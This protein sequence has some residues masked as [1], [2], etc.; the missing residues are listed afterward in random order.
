MF[1]R[2]VVCLRCIFQRVNRRSL[3]CC[4]IGNEAQLGFPRVPCLFL[5]CLSTCCCR[6]CTNARC[7]RIF[8]LSLRLSARRAL[9][10]NLPCSAVPVQVV[11]AAMLTDR[12]H[13]TS[14]RSRRR[15]RHSTS[16]YSSSSVSHISSQPQQK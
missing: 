7:G 2:T 15:R 11:R 9:F 8:R 10:I 3:F 4:C 13:R 6:T 14:T 5:V 12:D 1:K 16:S